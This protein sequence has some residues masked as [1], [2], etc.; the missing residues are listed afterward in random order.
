MSKV[1]DGIVKDLKNIPESLRNKMKG[2]DKG[3]LIRMSI[4][5]VI[6]GYV[7]DKTAW[8]YRHTAGELFPRLM[9]TA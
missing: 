2:M 4:P 6:V 7:C 5:Y 1:V 8:M 3:R 9:D